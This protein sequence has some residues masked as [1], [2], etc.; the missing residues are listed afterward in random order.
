V[1]ASVHPGVDSGQSMSAIPV[2]IS[3]VIPVH[4]GEKYL[5]Q[6]IQSVLEQ[7][8]AALE[9]L[10]VDNAS[11]D[12]TAAIARTFPGIRYFY[13]PHKGMVPALNHGVKNSQG[14]F[15][16]FLDADDLWKSHKL[17]AQ[18]EVFDRNPEVDLVFGHVEQFISHE[19][20]ESDSSHLL[21]REKELPGYIRGT[22][23]IKKESFW[24][25]G[26]FDE[27]I[28]YGEFIDWYMRAQEQGLREVMLP[29]VLLMRRIHGANMGYLESGRRID[30]V[31]VL[32][33]GLDRR[34]RLGKA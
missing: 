31:R 2:G 10:I 6:C 32:K 20:D 30:Y 12:A 21:I 8:H 1:K 4:N 13:L 5:A 28:E 16:C 25:V 7:N 19:L 3:A 18:L 33:R 15:L 14:D 34:R 26:L 9:I 22:M 23:L 11:T 27:A 24:R 17:A 29:D